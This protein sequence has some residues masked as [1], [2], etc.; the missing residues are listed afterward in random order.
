MRKAICTLFFRPLQSSVIF[1][2]EALIYSVLCDIIEESAN[3]GFKSPSLAEIDAKLNELAM[4]GG[5]GISLE[6]STSEGSG[7][8]TPDKEEKSEEM[9]E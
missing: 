4:T 7:A 1:L 9:T 5:F 2:R 8:E 3:T 6:D